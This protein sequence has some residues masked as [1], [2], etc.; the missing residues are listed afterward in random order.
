[1]TNMNPT[2]GIQ[3]TGYLHKQTARHMTRPWERRFVVL[4]KAGMHWF[5]RTDGYDLFGEE[6][7]AVM[8]T[9]VT[10]VGPNQEQMDTMSAQILF[11][12]SN[13]PSELPID[14]PPS[15]PTQS[16]SPSSMV[17]VYS[18]VVKSKDGFTRIFR[19]S[20][21]SERERWIEAIT[22]TIASI[23][24]SQQKRA[25]SPEDGSHLDRK[26]SISGVDF[27]PVGSPFKKPRY[28]Y[29]S[30]EGGTCWGGSAPPIPKVIVCGD[31]VILEAGSSARSAPWGEASAVTISAGA[32]DS[33]K[34]FLSNGGCTTLDL[35]ALRSL[36][37]LNTNMKGKDIQGASLEGEKVEVVGMRYPSDPLLVARI[38]VAV[39][40]EIAPNKQSG[41]DAAGLS[42]VPM[43]LKAL[44]PLLLAVVSSQGLLPESI[45]PS[46]GQQAAF[47]IFLVFFAMDAA[48]DLARRYLSKPPP[49]ESFKVVLKSY[50][51]SEAHIFDDSLEKAVP[52]RF[53]EG[54][55]NDPP[56]TAEKRWAITSAWRK[57]ENIDTI[58]LQPHPYYNEIKRC[59]PH[60]YCRT[61]LTNQQIAYYE[62]PG[63]L[64]LKR[65]EEIGVPTMV[66]HYNFQ[67]EFCWTYMS[68]MGEQT[69]TLS[70]V[71][72]Q[73]VGLYDL[74]G[75][76]KEFLA[77][78][79]KISQEH[80]PERAGKICV[81]NAPGWFSMLW[82]VIKLTL[83]PNTQKKVF[84]LSESA[85]KKTMKTLIDHESVPTEYG[86]GLS[87]S[88]RAATVNADF[89]GPLGKDKEK[90]RWCSEYEVATDDYVKR[91]NEKRKLPLPPDV[92]FE[93]EDVL[94]SKEDYLAAY[95]PGWETFKSQ[96][97]LPRS[98]WDPEGWP[99]MLFT[100]N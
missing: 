66:W 4:T 37:E 97:H 24:Y 34:I 98:E 99:G 27:A 100:S 84:I 52:S 71:D 80:Y 28:L 85:A 92:A 32:K 23:Q 20:N 30:N 22:M 9:E 39:V 38:D 63:F 83:H 29:H 77:A 56:G 12:S 82:N 48:I 90:A 53:V 40:P 31:K 87:Y 2:F 46:L 6:T 95:E 64:Q 75:V 60:F 50:E 73:N 57:R 44:Q 26:E 72:V 5:R 76:V 47:V 14:T 3:M 45:L 41:S 91:L 11:S 89:E 86:G 94:I 15:A 19:C 93:R 42:V 61:D 62:R 10:S 55:K 33:L 49:R 7:G 1:M 69:R 58:I 67:I 21:E 25:E 36:S 70:G 79:S 17:T 59:Y 43:G 54:T 35:A 68:T 81:L 96:L 65:L 18:F 88:E 8:L 78:I 13:D 74:K 16:S 51:E